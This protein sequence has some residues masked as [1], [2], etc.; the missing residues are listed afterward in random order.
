MNKREKIML[1]IAAIL[2]VLAFI[3]ITAFIVPSYSDGILKSIA[4]V[5]FEIIGIY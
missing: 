5:L 1:I 2:I 3:L 4:K